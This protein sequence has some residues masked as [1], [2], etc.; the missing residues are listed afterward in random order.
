[1]FLDSNLF[2][3][4]VNLSSKS[5]AFKQGS[6]FWESINNK[7]VWL[8]TIKSKLCNGYDYESVAIATTVYESFK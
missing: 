4:S 7:G 3:R 8:F 6:L 1:M 5:I 2:L